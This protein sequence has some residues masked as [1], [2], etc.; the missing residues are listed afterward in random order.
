MFAAPYFSV[1]YFTF[2]YWPPAM[3]W[4]VVDDA[5]EDWTPKAESSDIWSPRNE[6]SDIWT[7]IPVADNS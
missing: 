2:H 5:V 7:P 1:R 4:M 6:S 3:G